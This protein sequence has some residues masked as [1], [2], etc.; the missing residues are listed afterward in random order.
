MSEEMD[1]ILAEEIVTWK[2]DDPVIRVGKGDPTVGKILDN[3]GR[4][5][6]NNANHEVLVKFPGRKAEWINADELVHY[7]NRTDE[8]LHND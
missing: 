7:D 4:S 8:D 2:V 3:G 1:H 5:T 6:S